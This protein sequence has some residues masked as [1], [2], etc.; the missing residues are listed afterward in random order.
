[1]KRKVWKLNLRISVKVRKVTTTYYDVV[2][3]KGVQWAL[4]DMNM[5]GIVD[6]TDIFEAK[7]SS[8]CASNEELCVIP[9][10][11]KWSEQ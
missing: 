4:L 8:A 2:L 9:E 5:D 6:K 3:S 11:D 7:F 10:S 1:M